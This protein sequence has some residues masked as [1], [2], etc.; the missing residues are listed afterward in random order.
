MGNHRFSLLLFSF[1]FA[2]T[3]FAGDMDAKKDF[4]FTKHSAEITATPNVSYYIYSK[5]TIHNPYEGYYP[6]LGFTFGLQYMYR[7]IKVFAVSAGL[8][9]HMQS[10]YERSENYL[11]FP[12]GQYLNWRRILNTGYLAVPLY[13][14]LFKSMPKSTFE[15]AVGPDFYIPVFRHSSWTKFDRNDEKLSSGSQME[16]FDSDMIHRYASFGLSIF[17]G[18]QLYL[19]PKADLFIGPQISFINLAFF[20]KEYQQSRANTGRFSDVNLGL[21]LGFRLHPARKEASR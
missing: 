9:F 14:H 4:G 18:A 2:F 17:L 8:N 20:D 3:V 15:F 11:F 12:S 5:S 16:R 19:C 1:A 13:L 10:L 21:K 7:P 6:F